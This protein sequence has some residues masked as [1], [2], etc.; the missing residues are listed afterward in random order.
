MQRCTA[1]QVNDTLQYDL[2]TS[3]VDLVITSTPLY[4]IESHAPKLFEWLEACVS[5]D[6]IVLLDL[7]GQYN[8]YTISTWLGERSTSWQFQWGYA[9]HDFYK[10]GDVQSLCAY[11]RFEVPRPREIPYNRCT[12][13]DMSHPCE[14][15]AKLIRHLIQ[16]YSQKYQTVL[17]PFCGTGTVPRQAY[18]L[19]RN[20]LGMDR[21][22]PFTNREGK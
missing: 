15:D 3:S 12:E 6:G 18:K 4:I 21:R 9:L 14:F 2:G 11:A 8:K 17:D 10:V 19:K 1:I 5:L 16:R 22:C 7:P 13:R 20:G